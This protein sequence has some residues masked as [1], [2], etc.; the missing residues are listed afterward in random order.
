MRDPFSPL[1]RSPALGAGLSASENLGCCPELQPGVLEVD[2]LQELQ[3]STE[4][5]CLC[6]CP[7]YALLGVFNARNNAHDSMPAMVIDGIAPTQ[8]A[9]Q[10]T[11]FDAFI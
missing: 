10:R 2:R 9:R 8:H 5:L 4:H 7:A 6:L 1:L 3:F 11:A